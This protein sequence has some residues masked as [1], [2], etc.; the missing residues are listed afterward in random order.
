M[1]S[2]Q[3][4]KAFYAV[5]GNKR[6]P[7]QELPCNFLISAIYALDAK[8]LY[9]PN[10]LACYEWYQLYFRK[11]LEGIIEGR[12]YS[13]I[14]KKFEN[15]EYTYPEFLKLNLANFLMWAPKPSRVIEISKT[16]GL[17]SEFTEIIITSEALNIG[18][19]PVEERPPMYNISSFFNHS[20]LFELIAYSLSEWLLNND[21]RK[22]K[23]CQ[24]CEKFYVQTKLNPKQKYCSKCSPKSKMSKERRKE[25]QKKYR[26]KKKQEKL[27]IQR[28]K[29][30]LRI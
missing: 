4:D 8:L 3:L 11:M 13:E 22:L 27:A 24:G 15:Q 23:Y 30:G 16:S 29:Q 1:N 21:R 12:E 17:D 18:E 7:D 10:K 26:Q 19:H 2:S 14:P 5:Y 28:G 20:I 6:C 9:G 25:Y